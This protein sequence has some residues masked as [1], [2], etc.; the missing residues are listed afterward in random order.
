[1]ILQP[2]VENAIKYAVARS[3]QGGR[4]SL[5]AKIF[6]NELLIELKDDGPGMVQAEHASGGRGVG[7][8]NTRER[9]TQLYGDQ[10]TFSLSKAE[11]QGL[12]INIR[13]PYEVASI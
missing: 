7:L 13:L 3:E 9:L 6:S 8:G 12:Q 11:P 2:L 1:L 4:I 10:H 5:K